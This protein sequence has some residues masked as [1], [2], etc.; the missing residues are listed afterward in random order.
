[1]KSMERFMNS[2]KKQ[3]FDKAGQSLTKRYREVIVHYVSLCP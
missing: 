1:M 2:L 3:D